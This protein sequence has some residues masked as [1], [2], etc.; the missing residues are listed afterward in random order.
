MRDETRSVATDFVALRFRGLIVF[1]LISLMMLTGSSGPSQ[2][3]TVGVPDE[4]PAQAVSVPAAAPVPDW[5]LPNVQS[6]P[7]AIVRAAPPLS[8]MLP[9]LGIMADVYVLPTTEVQ[10]QTRNQD[11]P[12]D[13]PHVYWSGLFG[14]PGE[15]AADMT[16]LL[17]HTCLGLVICTTEVWPLNEM[18][19]RVMIGDAVTIGTKNGQVCYGVTQVIDGI[20][21]QELQSRADI[22]G[23]T[24]LP[25]RLVIITCD[26][27]DILGA[28]YVV[29]A[30][31]QPCR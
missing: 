22:F 4:G 28:Q 17:G 25:G 29:I 27:K 10:R 19:G 24:P 9:R 6:Q 31:D 3:N 26:L 18:N 8:I 7:Q 15:G 16:V 5:P 23:L 12:K 13:S 20:P 2:S 11:P 30:E 14:Q 21:K 1:L